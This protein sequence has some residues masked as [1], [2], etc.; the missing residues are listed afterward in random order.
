MLHKRIRRTLPYF[1]PKLIWQFSKSYI[2]GKTTQDAINVSKTLNREEV[3]VTLDILGK[4]IKT[5][6]Q[7]AKDR[8]DHLAL[9][10]TIEAAGI[11]GNYS[12]YAFILF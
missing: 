10:H 11:N 2:A 5:I 1:P 12:V 6:S 7:A 8:D 9:I 3:M 4:L